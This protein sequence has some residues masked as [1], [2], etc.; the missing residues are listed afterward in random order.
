[1]WRG[2]CA[3]V[4]LRQ[5]CAGVNENGSSWRPPYKALLIRYADWFGGRERLNDSFFYRCYV[6]LAYPEH[7]RRKRLEERFFRRVI[8]PGSSLVFD[9]G[10]NHGGKAV[11]FA[12]MTRRVVCVEPSPA[13]A[14]ILRCRFAGSP[15][16]LIEESGVHSV[17]G[18]AAF[19][20]H[21]FDESS[22]LNTFSPKWA[23]EV[24]KREGDAKLVTVPTV[25]LES[26][27]QKNAVCRTT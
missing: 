3:P 7:A 22:A 14:K 21:V 18:M 16:I 24:S 9:I 17:N 20:F 25:T 1:M 26:L 2:S 6:A 27:I 11:I 10:A 13:S 8:P 15:K 19:A 4:R 5:F 12:R 23:G